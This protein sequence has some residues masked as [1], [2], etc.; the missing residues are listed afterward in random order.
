MELLVDSRRRRWRP[1]SPHGF[2]RA[3]AQRVVL[4]RGPIRGDHAADRRLFGDR[5][6]ASFHPIGHAALQIQ[7]DGKRI[8]SDPSGDPNTG[9]VSFQSGGVADLVLISHIHADHYDTKALNAI[10]GPNTV[11]LA[12]QNV[13]DVMPDSLKAV[14][15]VITNGQTK[16]VLGIPVEA[17]AMYNMNPSRLNFHPKGLGNGYVLTLGGKRVYLSGDTEDT[18]EMRALKNMDVAYLCMNLPFTMDLQQAASAVR[19][20]KPKV[21]FPYHF[22]SSRQFNIQDSVAFKK[23]VG[24][25]PG[26]EVR[27]RSWYPGFA[28]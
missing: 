19:E 12:P 2:R 1:D 27:L 14:T 22:Y 18:P 8:Y 20:F 6:N 21:V 13:F 5:G 10:K 7:G 11:I 23:L 4:P 9:A 26:I 16:T 28:Q 24:A 25:D 15:T 3:G 17:V